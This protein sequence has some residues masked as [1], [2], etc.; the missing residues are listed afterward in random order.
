MGQPGSRID[1]Q[2]QRP[3]QRT[4]VRYQFHLEWFAFGCTVSTACGGGR[5]GHSV[6]TAPVLTAIALIAA[7]FADEAGRPALVRLAVCHPPAGANQDL[8]EAV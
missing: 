8:G 2:T 5:S 6:A 4:W 7:L 3:G 1:S